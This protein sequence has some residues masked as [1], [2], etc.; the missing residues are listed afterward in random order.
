MSYVY[1]QS[2]QNLWTVGLYDPTGEWQPES[3]HRMPGAA[4]ARVRWLNGG[5]DAPKPVYPPLP[6]GVGETIELSNGDLAIIYLS[7]AIRAR[8]YSDGTGQAAIRCGILTDLFADMQKSNLA[9]VVT[10]VPRKDGER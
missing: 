5:N 10:A 4:A 1:I 3:D 2:E 6:D 9:A 7:L 8:Q